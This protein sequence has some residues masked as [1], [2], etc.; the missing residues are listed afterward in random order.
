MIIWKIQRDLRNI[1]EIQEYLARNSFTHFLKT[2]MRIENVFLKIH[3]F[4]KIA[5]ENLLVWNNI[6]ENPR[7]F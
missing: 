3:E 1:I 6:L 5:I 2:Q 4:K 7:I